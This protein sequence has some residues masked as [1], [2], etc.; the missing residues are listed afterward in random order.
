MGSILKSGY[1]SSASILCFHLLLW[2]FGLFTVGLDWP[3]SCQTQRARIQRRESTAKGPL[4][5]PGGGKPETYN[6][7]SNEEDMGQDKSREIS[8]GRR[9]KANRPIESCRI[10]IKKKKRFIVHE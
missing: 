1:F 4:F 5:G 2:P 9:V 7:I 10:K 6:Y 8:Q 3:S